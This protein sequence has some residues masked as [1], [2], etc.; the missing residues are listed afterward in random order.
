MFRLPPVLCCWEYSNDMTHRGSTLLPTL[1]VTAGL[2]ALTTTAILAVHEQAAEL[3]AHREISCARGAAR[4]IAALWPQ[5]L[6]RLA[7]VEPLAED[8]AWRIERAATVGE[9]PASSPLLGTS[10]SA[11]ILVTRARCGEARTEHRRRLVDPA[12][13]DR[14]FP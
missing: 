10:E 6:N 9:D 2:S 4:S 1:L 5:A 7:T 14:G 13:C 8:T 12:V 11:C 3:R